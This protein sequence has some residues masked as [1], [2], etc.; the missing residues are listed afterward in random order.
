M[1]KQQHKIILAITI[2]YTVL[3]LYFIFLAFGRVGTVDRVTGYTFIWIPDSFF[4]LPGLSDLLHPTLMDLVDCGNVAAFIPFGLF[5]PLLY[6][7][8]FIRFMI[9]FIL[10]IV[11]MEIIQALTLLGSFD[12]NDVIQNSLG[13]AVGYGA[14]KFGCRTSNVWKNIAGAGLSIAVLMI[15]IWGS[16]GIVDKALPKN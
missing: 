11:A 16:F 5:I 14:Y 7:T 6:R 15:V 10:S 4:R 2:S 12:I 1:T 13:A 8:G 9:L 3:I